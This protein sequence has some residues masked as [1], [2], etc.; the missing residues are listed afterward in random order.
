MHSSYVG[1]PS[2]VAVRLSR[3]VL[4]VLLFCVLGLTI[5]MAALS[6]MAP[7]ELAAILAY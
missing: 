4:A 1:A 2:A 5:S 3:N 6:F 7:E